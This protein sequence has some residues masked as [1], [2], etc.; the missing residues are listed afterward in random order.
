M[1]ASTDELIDS[2]LEGR[3][4]ADETIEQ[5]QNAAPAVAE[6][7]EDI[8]ANEQTADIEEVTSQTVAVNDSATVTD[9]VAIGAGAAIEDIAES[10]EAT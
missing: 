9:S 7:I 10:E 4:C 1:P 6:I 3:Y 8:M 5:L 2:I